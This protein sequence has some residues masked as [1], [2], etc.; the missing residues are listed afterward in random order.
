[1]A[2]NPVSTCNNSGLLD[3]QT[4]CSNNVAPDIIEK[5]ALDP[6]WGHYEALAL[7]RWF[8]DQVSPAGVLNQW[9]T[10]TTFGWGVGG[11]ALLPIWP[12]FVDLQG[13]VL[14]GQG[15]GRY[16]SSQLPDAV[17]GSSG[18]VQPIT[19]VQFL[20][21]AVAHPSPATTSMSITARS[22]HKL[23]S[24]PSVAFRV[25]G[26]IPIS[27][28]AAAATRLRRQGRTLL[29]RS[30]STLPRPVPATFNAPRK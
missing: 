22:R 24:G 11:S 23:T 10:K 15:I 17:I 12:K 9:G 28:R 7:Q 3:N 14:Y 27:S 4:E 20:V 25:V 13:S 16:A 26:V 2:L 19:S 8:S 29:P 21:G 1:M 5:V 18:Q 30:T 6:G